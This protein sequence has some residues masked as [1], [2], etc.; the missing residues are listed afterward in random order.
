MISID[1]EAKKNRHSLMTSSSERNNPIL[2][3][4]FT[5]GIRTDTTS[6][7]QFGKDILML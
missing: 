2:P 4:L 1:L 6:Q 5:V 7:Y 3:I